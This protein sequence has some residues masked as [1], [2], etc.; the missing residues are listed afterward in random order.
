M[1][2]VRDALRDAGWETERFD[3]EF[4]DMVAWAVAQ[5]AN[6]DPDTIRQEADERIRLPPT[7]T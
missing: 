1:D 3:K 2:T 5:V 6:L 4:D 7:V